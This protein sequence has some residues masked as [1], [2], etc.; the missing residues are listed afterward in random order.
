MNAISLWKGSV[1][2]S[3]LKPTMREIAS[4]VAH[5]HGLTLEDLKGPSRRQEISQPRQEAMAL[6]CAERRWSLPQI[7]R[8]FGGRDHT[9]VIHGVR[10][11]QRRTEADS[12]PNGPHE[13]P[14]RANGGAALA[15]KSEGSTY[16]AD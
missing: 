6:M 10:A 4:E 8:F 3:A 12:I 7:G 9:T 11:H 1:E 14:R 13:K 15:G 5:R 2:V 16:Y